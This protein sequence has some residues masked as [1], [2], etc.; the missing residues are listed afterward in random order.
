MWNPSKLVKIAFVNMAMLRMNISIKTHTQTLKPSYKTTLIIDTTQ[1]SNNE[2]FIKS[3]ISFWRKHSTRSRKRA[4]PKKD[5]QQQKE[6]KILT[7]EKLIK[8]KEKKW[9]IPKACTRMQ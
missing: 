3:T 6:I 9:K 5:T 4:L 1:V 8:T 7:R 2:R